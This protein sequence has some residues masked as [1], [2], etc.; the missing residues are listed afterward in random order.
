M[1]PKNQI[2]TRIIQEL[3]TEFKLVDILKV[4]NFPK[5]TYHYWIK[6]M[7][8][9]NP[10]QELEELIFTIFNENH[11]NYG[12]RRITLELHNRG[13]RVN[14]KKVYRLMKKL[15]LICIKFSH[16]TRNYRSYKGT[17]G[18]VAKNRMNR[19]FHTPH[20][21]QKLTTDVTEF[22][23]QEGKKLYL[24]PILDMATGEILSF[25]IHH[26]PDLDFVMKSLTDILPILEQAKYRTTIHSDQ[27]WHYQHQKWVKTLKR[28]KIFQSM[29]RKGN[30]LDNSL[31]ENFFGILK[32][33]M[34][35]GKIFKTYEELKE[36]I[37][38]YIYYYNHKRIKT[39]LAGMSPVQYRIHTSQ[40]A[41]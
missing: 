30:C 27:G 6:K 22:K 14:H 15:G 11:E 18:T 29:S 41:A 36:A 7:K 26:R 12:Y 38:T 28:N 20:A 4:T 9:E 33:E 25:S 32:Q 1:E 10:N 5:S 13:L 8:Q 39:K 40:W 35:Y 23:T 34:Y 2:E 3:T 16:K 19:R 24:S 37:E 17:I 21:Y 31:M